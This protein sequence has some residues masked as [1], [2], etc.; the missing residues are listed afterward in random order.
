MMSMQMLTLPPFQE[1]FSTDA[2][3]SS[4]QIMKHCANVKMTVIFLSILLRA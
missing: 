4:L 2:C 1:Y 3:G